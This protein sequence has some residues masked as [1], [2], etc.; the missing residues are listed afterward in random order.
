MIADLIKPIA[1]DVSILGRPTVL[2]GAK[3][4]IEHTVAEALAG[5]DLFSTLRLAQQQISACGGYVG[6]LWQSP[7][8]PWAMFATDT[9]NMKVL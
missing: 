9:A 2:I 7:F 1:V 4:F 3:L 6:Q 5:Y 8:A